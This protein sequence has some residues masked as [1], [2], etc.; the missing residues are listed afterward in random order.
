M[1]ARE[2]I[3]KHEGRKNRP[4]KCPAG[5]N[6]IGVG[7]NMDANP[8]PKDI[9]DYLKANGRVLDDHIERLLTMSINNAVSGCKKL[10]PEFEQMSDNRKMALTD[11]IFQLGQGGARKFIHTIAAV[12]ACQWEDAADFMRDSLWARQCPNRAAEVTELIEAG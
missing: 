10:F 8:L 2:F 5:F 9:A 4:Y 6:T 1:T 12:N 11:F 7:W 3:T